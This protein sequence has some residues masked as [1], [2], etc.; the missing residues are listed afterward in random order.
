VY[1]A[2]DGGMRVLDIPRGQRLSQ[3]N[4]H[5]RRDKM[6]SYLRRR[7]RRAYPVSMQRAG[8]SDEGP[9]LEQRQEFAHW[10]ED[11]VEAFGE[12]P[13]KWSVTK[14][15]EKGGIH[16]NAIYDWIGAR[17][18]PKRETVARFCRGL[19]LE[20]SEPAR[21]LGWVEE[22]EAP[23]DLEAYIVRAR[24]IASHPRTSEQRREVLNIRIRG[25]EEALKMVKELEQQARDRLK[26]VMDE[27]EGTNDR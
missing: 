12:P 10:V 5:I 13:K 6:S 9:T 23:T 2:Y 11:V 15:A 7:A 18:T 17:A 22:S 24:A 14:I 16:R 19:G 4:L 20:F 26:Q 1:V 8:G 27:T 25:A 3:V 21:L